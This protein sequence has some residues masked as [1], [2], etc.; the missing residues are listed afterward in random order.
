MNP[1]ILHPRI[2]P[3]YAGSTYKVQQKQ[4]AEDGSSPHTRGARPL[5]RNLPH[6]PRII[7]AYAGSTSST[8]A[9]TTARA[10]HPRIRGEHPFEPSPHGGLTGSSPHTRGAPCSDDDRFGLVGII[11]AYAGS[12]SVRCTAPRATRDH[13]RIR[14]EHPSAPSKT[15]ESLGS[16]PHTRGAP[17]RR[18]LSA[19]G[20]RIIPAYAGSTQQNYSKLFTSPGSSPH[21]R[22]ALHVRRR[23]VYESG[24]IPAYAGSTSARNI[25]IGSTSDHPRIRGEHYAAHKVAIEAGG[26]SPHTRGALRDVFDVAPPPRIIPAYAGSTRVDGV[27]GHGVPDHPRIRGE[28]RHP[29]RRRAPLGRNLDHPRIRGEHSIVKP[30]ERGLTGSSPHTRG[31]PIRTVAS[32]KR[33]RIIPAYAGS[34]AGPRRDGRVGRDHPRIRGEHDPPHA[35]RR[36]RVGSSPH[37][38]GAL[39]QLRL[40]RAG[41]RII[42]AYAGSTDAFAFIHRDDPDHPRIRGEH[43]G[44]KMT[45]RELAGSSPHTRG[46]LPVAKDLIQGLGIIPA[47]AGST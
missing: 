44:N 17:M 30:S 18:F 39:R 5:W 22:G 27:G 12:T 2:I 25:A 4:M 7:P 24:I 23:A 46:A 43:P 20:I 6:R 31:A 47:Y 10:D 1:S 29:D 42:P 11:P 14:G 16:S 19:C 38:R 33:W 45:V 3:A 41:G 34:T 8:R 40:P 32:A 37:T 9:K 26:S 13:P 15:L 28:H 21:T 36:R 35:P